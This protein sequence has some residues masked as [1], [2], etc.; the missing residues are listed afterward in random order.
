M[1]NFNR[2]EEARR[3]RR[4]AILDDGDDDTPVSRGP[5]PYEGRSQLYEAC[6]V[7]VDR[8]IADPDQPR[9]DFDHEAMSRLAGSIQARGQL[10]PIRVRWDAEKGVYVVVVGER[11]WRAAR[12]LDMETIACVVVGGDPSPV[13]ILEDQLVEN[14]LR[15][16]LKPVEQARAYRTL[17]DSLGLSQRDLAAKLRISPGAVTQA[18]ALLDLPESVRDQVERGN[19]PPTVAY[20]IGKV[21]DPAAQSDLAARVV[22]DGLSR[23]DTIKAVR[24]ASGRSKGRGAVRPARPRVFRTPHGKVTVEPRRGATPDAIAAALRAAVEMAEGQ[25]SATGAA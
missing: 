9:K 23:A 10:Q 11:R 6:N 1:A 17:M 7:R 25:G 13:E 5:D 18:L 19:L 22:A 3:N 20:E 21:A 14:A 4:S 8:I 12:L 15:E 2:S 24:Q 16:G